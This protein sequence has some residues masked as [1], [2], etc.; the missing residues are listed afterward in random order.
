MTIPTHP[1]EGGTLRY[2]GHLYLLAVV[3]PARF[4]FIRPEG[5]TAPV[6][7]GIGNTEDL[8]Q[9]DEGWWYTPGTEHPH[10]AATAGVLKDG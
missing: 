6:K 4:S 10:R 7:T 3:S 9:S 8:Q 2:R 5:S 1:A